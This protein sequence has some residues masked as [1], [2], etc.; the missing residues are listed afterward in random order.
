[1]VCGCEEISLS[2]SFLAKGAPN[3][4]ADKLVHCKLPRNI[5]KCEFQG[6]NLKGRLYLGS[7][8]NKIS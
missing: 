8:C 1:M 7:S 3:S 5:L 6:L 2:L 4:M